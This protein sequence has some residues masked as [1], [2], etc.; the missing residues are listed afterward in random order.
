MYDKFYILKS[1][2]IKEKILIY[3]S[4]ELNQDIYINNYFFI[5]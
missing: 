5:L 4:E 3:F 2:H 1:T